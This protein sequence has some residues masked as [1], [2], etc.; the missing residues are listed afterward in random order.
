MPLP[1]RNAPPPN[2]RAGWLGVFGANDVTAARRNGD[3][4]QAGV[5]ATR[6]IWLC[7]DDYG[8]ARGVDSAIRDL[9]ARGRINATSVMVAAAAF[10][11]TEADALAA[12]NSG[13]S[14]AAI[15]LHVTLTAPFRPLSA[16]YRPPQ[17]GAFPSLGETLRAAFSRR[18]DPQA[19]AA[20]VKAQINAFVEAFGRPPDFIDG[21]QHVHLFPQIRD[22]VLTVAKDEAPH[23]WLRQCGPPSLLRALAADRKALFL[24]FLSRAF[25]RRARRLGVRTNPAFAGTYNFRTDANFAALFPTFLAQLPVDSVVM[26]HPGIVDDELKR[27]DPLTHA[28]EREYALFASE[29]FPQMLAAHGVALA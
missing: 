24:G 22:A 11:R 28:R 6:R 13:T 20:E 21:H 5:P 16:G 9:I 7:A 26:C 1:R 3:N 4:A 8:I 23:A 14:R 2:E 15:G 18:L 10:D 12:L 29:S 19:L 27:I 17:G 25:R